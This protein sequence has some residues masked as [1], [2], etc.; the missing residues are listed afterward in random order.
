MGFLDSI[1]EG[2]VFDCSFVF[3]GVYEAVGYDGALAVGGR[4]AGHHA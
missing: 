1:D 4:E 2:G 3:L